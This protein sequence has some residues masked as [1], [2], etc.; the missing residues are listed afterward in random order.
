MSQGPTDS[1]PGSSLYP[2]SRVRPRT[3]HRAW[4]QSIPKPAYITF[5]NS[6]IDAN[7]GAAACLAAPFPQSLLG[8]N[9]LEFVARKYRARAGRRLAEALD[10]LR[11]DGVKEYFLRLDGSVFPV[12]F[13]AAAIRHRHSRALL[14]IFEEDAQNDPQRNLDSTREQLASKLYQCRLSSIRVLVECCSILIMATDMES[15]TA[16]SDHFLGQTRRA[17][18]LLLSRY[19]ALAHELRSSDRERLQSRIENLRRRLKVPV[20]FKPNASD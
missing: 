12:C 6:V 1:V 17:Y 3:A 9:P 5:H 18:D 14:V 8:A 16:R 7:E 2:F 10:G 4:L 15:A 19:R 13:S 11:T 20:T